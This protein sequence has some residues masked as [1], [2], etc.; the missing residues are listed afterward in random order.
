MKKE[1]TGTRV[2]RAGKSFAALLVAVIVCMPVVIVVLGSLKSGNELSDSLR[3]VF[4]DGSTDTYI[5]WK[6]LALYPTL[7]HYIRLFIWTPDFFVVFWNSVKIVACILAGQ[8]LIAVPAAWAFAAFTWKRKRLVFTLYVVLMLLP[9]Q[10]TMLP[11]YLVMNRL[12]LFNTHAA[13]ILPAVFSTFPVFMVYRGFTAIPKELLDAARV[14]GAGEAAVFWEIGIPL[15]SPG[16]LS[17]A[18]LGFLDYWNMIEQPLAFLKEKTLWPLSLYLP[19]VQAGHAGIS[20]AACVTALVPA[21]LVFLLG[22]DYLEQGIT[23]AGLKA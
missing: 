11:S 6:L 9:F 5:R 7:R 2:K 18:V 3:P 13:V 1:R 22:Q 14:E 17:A 15:G 8:L 4:S 23:A 21:A 16:I 12:H 20:L 19:Q 10:V